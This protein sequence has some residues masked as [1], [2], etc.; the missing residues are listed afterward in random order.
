MTDVSI[1]AWRHSAATFSCFPHDCSE[2]FDVKMNVSSV[3]PCLSV[4]GLCGP[5]SPSWT[6]SRW[7]CS[8]MTGGDAELPDLVFLRFKPDS[9]AQRRVFLF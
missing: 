6:Y 5:E 8:W 9:E 7:D 2:S 4:C 1:T 3:W